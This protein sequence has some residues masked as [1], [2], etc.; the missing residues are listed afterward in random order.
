MEGGKRTQGEKEGG[1]EWKGRG[2][3]RGGREER[4]VRDYF[5]MDTA[6]SLL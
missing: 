6:S 2:E 3:G 4:W 5:H 1:R